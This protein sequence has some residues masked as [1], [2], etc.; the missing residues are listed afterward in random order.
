MCPFLLQ[1]LLVVVRWALAARGRLRFRNVAERAG[2]SCL[3][4]P[5]RFFKE[6]SRRGRNRL[7][8]Y[9]TVLHIK[10]WHSKMMALPKRR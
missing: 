5:I 6:H 4:A 2:A 10:Y 1:T 7:G 9:R 3:Y 8:G